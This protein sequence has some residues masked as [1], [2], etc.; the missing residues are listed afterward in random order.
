MYTRVVRPLLFS[1]ST[2]D[3]ERTHEWA[4]QLLHYLGKPHWLAKATASLMTVQD[5]VDLLG[6]HFPNRVGLAAGFDKNA[7]ALWGLWALGFGFLEVGTV[8]AQEQ[9]GN[10]RPR[11][12]RLPE[13][14]ALINAMGFNN[15]GATGV[16]RTLASLGRPS[17]PIGISLGKSMAVPP[18][19]MEAVV[20]DYW[21]SLWKLYPFG[22]YFVINVSSPNTPGLRGLQD[23]T[24]LAMLVQELQLRKASLGKPKPIFIKISPDLTM[25]AINDILQVCCDCEIPGI[26]AT[27]T[28]T[29]RTGLRNTT[30]APGGLSG[31][32]LADMALS[33]VHHIRRQAPN[34]IIIGVGGI[35]TVDDARRMVEMAGADLIQ[36][37]TG[38]VYEG[39]MLPHRI[40]RGLRSIPARRG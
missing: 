34:L 32:P 22:D 18:E 27:N 35:F 8:T 38:L 31:R 21:F 12:W 10:P 6:L 37:Y 29:S 17:I 25:E 16:A 3:P 11:I 1:L 14:E 7:Q 13:E 20:E 23:K 5:P 19:N 30:N 40:A 36:L 4:I 33:A 15:H 26:I 2:E 9:P 24:Q 39:P 28:T